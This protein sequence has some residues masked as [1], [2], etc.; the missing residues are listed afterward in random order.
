VVA[1]DLAAQPDACEP[2]RCENGSL[3]IGHCGWLACHEFD[4]ASRTACIAAAGMQ[5]IDACLVG[6][7]QHEPLACRHLERA[8]AIDGQTGHHFLRRKALSVL[9]HW[10]DVAAL[11]FFVEVQLDVSGM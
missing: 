7:G 1:E 8:N 4:S 9:F 3:G 10:H 6:Q 11:Q 2:P 5:L